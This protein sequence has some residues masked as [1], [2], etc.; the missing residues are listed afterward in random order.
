LLRILKRRQVIV[1]VYTADMVLKL[2]LNYLGT[3]G[4]TRVT[5]DLVQEL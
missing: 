1:S 5:L 3:T 2:W 4:V